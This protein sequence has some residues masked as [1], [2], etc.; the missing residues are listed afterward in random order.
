MS[1]KP[2][3]ERLNK[4]SKK[5]LDKLEYDHTQHLERFRIAKQGKVE[6]LQ[7]LKKK[8]DG[9]KGQ[10]V[11]D[12]A[13]SMPLAMAKAMEMRHVKADELIVRSVISV[14]KSN[15]F[16]HRLMLVLIQ[17]TK[18]GVDYDPDR[19]KNLIP[20]EFTD[21]VSESILSTNLEGLLSDLAKEVDA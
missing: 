18:A 10:A 17:D 13:T 11:R 14:I 1:P 8:H 2:I 7:R 19:V 5:K 3:F 4:L 6:E 15:Q 9:L 20:Q 12:K 16:Y 21:M